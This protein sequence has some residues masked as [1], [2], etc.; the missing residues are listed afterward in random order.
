M[1]G[2]TMYIIS[3]LMLLRPLVKARVRCALLSPKGTAPRSLAT[4]LITKHNAAYGIYRWIA[5][6]SHFDN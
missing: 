3:T 4:Y 6:A 5:C 1:Y 2:L